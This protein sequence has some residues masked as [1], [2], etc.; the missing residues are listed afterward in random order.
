MTEVALRFEHEVISLVPE[1]ELL[2]RKVRTGH[3]LTANEE[4]DLARM[5]KR[6]RFI[7]HAAAQ[8]GSCRLWHLAAGTYDLVPDPQLHDR[9]YRQKTGVS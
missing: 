1:M 3:E 7:R 6:L 9:V 5:R 4:D 8:S 2:G